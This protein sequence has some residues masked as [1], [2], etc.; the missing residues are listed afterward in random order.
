MAPR[1]VQEI[2]E[3]DQMAGSLEEVG[4]VWR[5]V[6]P[7]LA[8]RRGEEKKINSFLAGG[9]SNIFYVHPYL[10]MIS[11]LTNSFQK[12]WNHQLVLE[13]VGSLS[14]SLYCIWI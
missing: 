9:N 2:S 7:T 6:V 10:G 1:N 3:W 13:G 11:N 8:A 4:P 12:G 14:L 5:R